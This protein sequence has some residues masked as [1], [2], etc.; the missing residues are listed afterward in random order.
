[1]HNS[2]QKHQ[3]K[4]T[5]EGRSTFSPPAISLTKIGGVIC[6]TGEKFAA[7][8]GHSGFGPQLSLSYDSGS[9]YGPFGFG[10]SLSIPSIT[11]E[12]DKGPPQYFNAEES[13]VLLLSGVEDLVLEFRKDNHARRAHDAKGSGIIF[14]YVTER[15]RVRSANRYQKY[16]RHGNRQLPSIAPT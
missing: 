9:S 12:T 6:G 14:K 3:E 11:R 2:P 15:Y 13:D 7:S 5:T 16:I 1:M 8:P 10:W 4:S